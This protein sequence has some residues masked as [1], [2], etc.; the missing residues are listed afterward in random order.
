MKKIINILAIVLIFSSCVSQKRCSKKFPCVTHDSVIYKESLVLYTDTIFI[1]IPAD[2]AKIQALVNCD[3]NGKAQML[4]H[5]VES[6]NQLTTVSI[7]DGVLNVNS[8]CKE[9]E[10]K[11]IIQTQQKT[12][13]SLKNSY[14]TKTEKYMPKWVKPYIYC[15]IPFILIALFCL[16]MFVRTVLKNSTR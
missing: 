15:S 1:N 16:Y 4:P 6:N 9:K 5:I 13:E 7:I 11:Q 10:L 14:F 12:I 2:T 8:E 3:S